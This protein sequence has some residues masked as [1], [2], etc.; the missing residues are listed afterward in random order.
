LERASE[1]VRERL[2]AVERAGFARLGR[3]PDL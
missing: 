3:E 2:L 1:L